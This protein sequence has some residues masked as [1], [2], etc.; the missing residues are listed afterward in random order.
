M[1]KTVFCVILVLVLV[2]L[3]ACGSEASSPAPAPSAEVEAT[4]VPPAPSASS[5]L[6]GSDI[7]ASP[8]GS[9]SPESPVPDEAAADAAR[10]CIGED[11]AVLFEA[12]GEPKDSSYAPSCLKPGGEDGELYYDGFTVATIREG[13]KEIVW[14]V[15]VNAG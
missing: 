8:A 11:V 14:D 4:P 10:A 12:I 5:V 7:Q 6:P 15:N 13:D 1:K 9:A 3:A 2:L